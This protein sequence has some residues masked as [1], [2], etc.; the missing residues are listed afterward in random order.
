MRLLHVLRM[1]VRSLF[2]RSEFDADARREMELHLDLLT[3]DKI[4]EGLS[5]PDA[6]AAAHRQ[7]GNL[8]Q[9]AESSRDVRG[10]RYLHDLIDDMRFA[11]RMLRKS[12]AFT[13]VS[14]LSLG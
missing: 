7:M 9:L 10:V 13:L 6:R 1:R 12:P 4:A 11:I 8:T 14:V 3:R 2:G 5:A